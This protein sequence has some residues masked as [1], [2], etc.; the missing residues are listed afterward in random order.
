M[1]NFWKDKACFTATTML[2]FTPWFI[3][4][5]LLYWFETSNTWT[6][7]T[8]QRDVMTILIL[9]TGMAATFLLL[10]YFSKRR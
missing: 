5:Y 3:S 9:L 6:S 7:E 2:G 4:M 1:S 10:S 8:N